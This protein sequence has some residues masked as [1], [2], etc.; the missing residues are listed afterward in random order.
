MQVNQQTKQLKNTHKHVKVEPA[1]KTLLSKTS[2][3]EFIPQL[4]LKRI[5]NENQL[6]GGSK[7]NL[8]TSV[9]HCRGFSVL[10]RMFISTVEV[11]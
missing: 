3:N 9:L 5:E 4:T 6:V 10:W 8:F 2:N 1:E 11:I 7:K